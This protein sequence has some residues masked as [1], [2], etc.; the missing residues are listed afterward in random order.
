MSLNL[1]QNTM[2]AVMATLKAND[3]ILVHKSTAQVSARFYKKRQALLRKTAVSACAVAD[4]N[5]L[6][7]Q[8]T[9]R[10]VKNMIKDGRIMPHEAYMDN[11]VQMVLVSAIKR[12]NNN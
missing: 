4:Y 7:S 3:L 5:L 12:I 11:G 9:R 10:T 6:D 8:P 1:D 2:D